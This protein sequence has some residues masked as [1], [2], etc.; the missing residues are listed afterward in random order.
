MRSLVQ[1]ITV[2][3]ALTLPASAALP[4]PADQPTRLGGGA[5]VVRADALPVQGADGGRDP[6]GYIVVGLGGFA[7]GAAGFAGASSALRSR[8]MVEA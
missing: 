6:L 8:R 3:L 5:Q 4:R 2:A 1:V 7:V